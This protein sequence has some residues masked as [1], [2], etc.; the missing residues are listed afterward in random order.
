M[1][2]CGSRVQICVECSARTKGGAS[3]TAKVLCDLATAEVLSRQCTPAQ[4]YAT[5]GLDDS[6]A[7]SVGTRKPASKRS[8]DVPRLDNALVTKAIAQRQVRCACLCVSSS[9]NA[10]VLVDM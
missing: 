6:A 7:V 10:R 4:V 5:L 9:G 3:P 2:S 8:K 1:F